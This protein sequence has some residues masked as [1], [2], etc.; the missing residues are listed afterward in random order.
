[1]TARIDHNGMVYSP[2]GSYR[3]F[4]DDFDPH[5]S[6]HS[7]VNTGL[8]IMDGNGKT[9]V[10]FAQSDWNAPPPPIF[11]ANGM[12]QVEATHPDTGVKFA[13]ALDS[14]RVR[15]C[16]R[17]FSGQSSTLIESDAPDWRDG[18]ADIEPLMLAA[19]KG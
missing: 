3:F 4:Y 2:C 14:V 13:L 5:P 6:F 11:P 8:R 7:S 17:I 16:F 19:A 1:M 9:I 15:F 12:A 18:L 10:D